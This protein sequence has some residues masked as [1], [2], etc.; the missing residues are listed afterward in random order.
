MHELIDQRRAARKGGAKE[1]VRDVSKSIKKEIQAVAKA[2]KRAKIAKVLAEFK[3][4]CRIAEIRGGGKRSCLSSVV[5]KD[6]E[7]KNYKPICIIWH[8]S[9]SQ[10]LC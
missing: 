3:D 4:L 8:K 9:F 2:R 1:T 7:E 5:D 6:G 10:V